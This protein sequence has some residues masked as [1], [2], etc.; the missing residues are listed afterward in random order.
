MKNNLKFWLGYLFELV[1]LL[2]LFIVIV[3][4]FIL[5]II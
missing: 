2:A 3:F 5:E 1:I 4:D